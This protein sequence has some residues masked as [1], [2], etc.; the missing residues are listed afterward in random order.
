MKGFIV[1][2]WTCS[3]VCCCVSLYTVTETSQQQNYQLAIQKRLNAVAL[4]ACNPVVCTRRNLVLNRESSKRHFLSLNQ[5]ILVYDLSRI[6]SCHPCCKFCQTL[7]KEAKITV[8]GDNMRDVRKKHVFQLADRRG[9]LT[10][11]VFG[12]IIHVV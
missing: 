12:G 2:V 6:A 4:L 7:I 9:K 11:L 1:R 3:S 5:S 10:L 8:L